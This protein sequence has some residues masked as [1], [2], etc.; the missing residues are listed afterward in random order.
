M[1]PVELKPKIDY[2]FSTYVTE[3]PNALDITQIN[4][5]RE[6]AHSDI[7]GLHR[8]GS[9][10]RNTDAS[11]YTCQ[12]HPLHDEIYEILDPLWEQYKSNLSFIEP[13][14][15]KSYVEGDLFDY[16]TDSYVN[17]V[18]NVDR[19][20]NLII[21]LSDT[22]EYDGGD[23]LVGRYQCTRQQG[24]AIFFPA[25]LM[26]CVTKVTRGTRYSLIGHGWGPHQI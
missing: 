22:N 8:R 5:L 3:I 7:S 13:Y 2:D 18:R 25:C 17:L 14:E 11:F 12:V 6:Y 4:R 24:N 16:H 10:D 15:I 21:Q 26:H 20:M 1:L 23:L 19:K 9:K